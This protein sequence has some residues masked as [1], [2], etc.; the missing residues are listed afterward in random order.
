[1]R[2]Y[3]VLAKKYSIYT[4]ILIII[5][6]V[7]A[8]TLSKTSF[9]LGLAFGTF[10]S[11]INLIITYF[12]VKR[13]IKTLQTGKK[14]WSPGTITRII[15]ALIPIYVA[16]QFPDIFQITG[17]IIGLMITY[18]IILIEPIFHIRSYN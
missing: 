5:F 17:V 1:M 16:T 3:H 6:L 18:V 9:F 15:S 14:K 13:V 12:Q 2:N 11:L 7:L 8:V 4:A 10:F